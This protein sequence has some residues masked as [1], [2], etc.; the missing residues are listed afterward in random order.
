VFALFLTILGAP[1]IFYVDGAIGTGT[2][3]AVQQKDATICSRRIQLIQAVLDVSGHCCGELVV[4]SEDVPSNPLLFVP[5][6]LAALREAFIDNPQEGGPTVHIV[7]C[8]GE[9][10]PY[11]AHDGR[12]ASL[13]ISDDS[14]FMATPG[15]LVVP[16]YGI[17]STP[18]GFAFETRDLSLVAKEL[19]LNEFGKSHIAEFV[20]F[21]GNDYTRAL[22]E[23]PS[24]FQEGMT[25]QSW[26]LMKTEERERSGEP[27]GTK[28]DQLVPLVSDERALSGILELIKKNHVDL[29]EAILFTRRSVHEPGTIVKE[30][31]AEAG[32]QGEACLREMP[33]SFALLKKGAWKHGIVCED[34]SFSV[35]SSSH[36][37]MP[38]I[39]SLFAACATGPLFGQPGS[40][41]PP[42]PPPRVSFRLGIDYLED[43]P[44][45]VLKLV[46]PG[47]PLGPLT[48]D[49][50]FEKR[51]ARVTS[52][53]SHCLT[54]SLGLPP[55]PIDS[56]GDP[57]LLLSAD[58]SAF[59][60]LLLAYLVALSAASKDP[61]TVYEYLS[62]VSMLGVLSSLRDS[63]LSPSSFLRS[64]T[65]LCDSR[66]QEPRDLSRGLSDTDGGMRDLTLASRSLEILRSLGSLTL[67]CGVLRGSA[68]NPAHFFHG[69]LF[70]L[71]L[72]AFPKM[73]AAREVHVDDPKSAITPIA[74][75]LRSL[76]SSLVQDTAGSEAQTPSLDLDT[77]SAEIFRL[78][79][80]VNRLGLASRISP[81]EYQKVT[82]PP[83]PAPSAAIDQ[84][85]DDSMLE[86]AQSQQEEGFLEETPNLIRVLPDPDLPV[87]KHRAEIL[88]TVRNNP[89]VVIEADTGAGKSSQIP[90]Y[91]LEET[92]KTS[93]NPFIVCTQPRR[94]SAI[95][96]AQR[97]ARERGEESGGTVSYA[98][99]HD[100]RMSTGPKKTKILY[101]T[102]G[103]LLQKILA[104]EDFF[105]SCSH[106][107]LDEI[108]ERSID[109]DL[110]TLLL[111]DLLSQTLRGE[112]EG[113]AIPPKLLLMSATVNGRLYSDYFSD[114]G[115][116]LPLRPPIL[117]VGG[118]LFPVV[119]H[120]LDEMVSQ[121]TLPAVNGLFSEREWLQYCL[122]FS[123]KSSVLPD[124]HKLFDL[125]VGIV[126][127]RA[128][129]VF[130]KGV[131]S[132]VLIF[133]PGIKSIE[134][135][136]VDLQECCEKFR[137]QFLHRSSY[138]VK[139]EKEG[140]GDYEE[141]E[142]EEEEKEANPAFMED[143]LR[144]SAAE[145]AEPLAPNICG[146]LE[147]LVLH[148]D[149][150]PDEQ[151]LAFSPPK[152]PGVLRVVLA[153]NL[154][155]SS[156]TIPGVDTVIDFGLHRE[157]AFDQ[158]FN[159]NRLET[160]WIARSSAIQ[161]AGRAG[162]LCPGT[163]WRLFTRTKFDSMVQF[164]VPE[165]LRLSLTTTVLRL[166][167]LAEK[168]TELRQTL[169]GEEG[170]GGAA[171]HAFS[172]VG[173]TLE[174]ALQPP[175]PEN[176]IAAVAQ[177][178][179]YGSL[180]RDEEEG[181]DPD[182]TFAP[183][184]PL[185]GGAGGGGGR[186]GEGGRGGGGGTME[187]VDQ[188]LEN[189]HVTKL[190]AF[191]HLLPLD[192][193]L[194]RLIALG[195]RTG[196]FFP[197]AIIM[198]VGLSLPSFYVRPNPLTW[199]SDDLVETISA[200]QAGV[201][202]YDAGRLSDA[203]AMIPL[204]VD[205]VASSRD[206]QVRKRLISFGVNLKRLRS[207]LRDVHE[208]TRRLLPAMP[209]HRHLLQMFL[210]LHADYRA[211]RRE[212][213]L[214]PSSINFLR[215]LVIEAL[216]LNRPLYR[217][218]VVQALQKNFTSAAELGAA[219][220][221]VVILKCSRAVPPPSIV[222]AFHT[223]SKN[224]ALVKVLRSELSKKQKTTATMYFD[225]AT[226]RYQKKENTPE[227]NS[228]VQTKSNIFCVAFRLLDDE[229]YKAERQLAEKQDPSSLPFLSVIQRLPALR[230]FLTMFMRMKSFRILR[231]QASSR[232]V[233]KARSQVKEGGEK[234]ENQGRRGR[235]RGNNNGGQGK[236]DNN[237]GTTGKEKYR[238]EEEE[239]EEEE[240]LPEET[241]QDG[242]SITIEDV[243]SWITF[244]PHFDAKGAH[245][246]GFS[247]VSNLAGRDLDP[248]RRW[249]LMCVASQETFVQGKALSSFIDYLTA[250]PDGNGLLAL[251]LLLHNSPHLTIEPLDAP[252]PPK[253]QPKK[254]R[255]P[256]ATLEADKLR[257]M[258]LLESMGPM[259]LSELRKKL[260][261]FRFKRTHGVPIRTAFESDP[262]FVVK[263]KQISLAASQ[264]AA[265]EE[266]EGEEG[267]ETRKDKWISGVVSP[268]TNHIYLPL[269]PKVRADFLK[270]PLFEEF[271]EMISDV[272]GFESDPFALPH[273]KFHER[274]LNALL[275]SMPLCIC[276]GEEK[277]FVEGRKEPFEAKKERPTAFEE[278]FY[279]STQHQRQYQSY[280][281]V[282]QT[283]KTQ[284]QRTQNNF[285]QPKAQAQ[286]SNSTQTT[287]P[288]KAHTQKPQTTTQ[289]KAQ[290]QKSQ[291]SSAQT[292][293]PPKAQPKVTPTTK[294]QPLK[295]QTTTQQ[296][297]AQK[298]QSQLSLRLLPPPTNTQP[299][300]SQT[301]T[302]QPKAQAQQLPPSQP[303][304]TPTAKTQ[305]QKSQTTTQQPKVQT[306]TAKQQQSHNTA[307]QPK[308]EDF[309]EHVAYY[310]KLL[311]YYDELQIF[312]R[313]KEQK[314][315]NTQY[316][317]LMKL[318]EPQR[319][320][321]KKQQILHF[322]E[323]Q[324]HNTA[325]LNETFHELRT[326]YDSLSLKIQIPNIPTQ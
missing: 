304:A 23:A 326:L 217:G 10:D 197:H 299:L 52:P 321:L 187:D 260:G 163:V 295:S 314:L 176:V 282:R 169:A 307:A 308:G 8:L 320:S 301:T 26:L 31:I 132:T 50:S 221:H 302:Q 172:K 57:S 286:K 5:A 158:K 239:E 165:M 303:K 192:L 69:P 270:N 223:F 78:L 157:V 75:F 43:Q 88:E 122:A 55:F 142:E 143:L 11:L 147:V 214:P 38:L 104:S 272:T 207:F 21:A 315:K 108:H 215:L 233:A 114:L 115:L 67:L 256:S 153:T 278:E 84:L 150:E 209:K 36:V 2:G 245:L 130:T 257:G 42:L 220:E 126:A 238:E 283:P 127:C 76:L 63:P 59:S 148:S 240:E 53:L 319:G 123:S 310:K 62:F 213:V 128:N 206:F 12:L 171:E 9:A 312:Y 161:R 178:V 56:L 287:Q 194:G 224:F 103:W 162:R 325:K 45:E 281:P 138:R 60:S 324:R 100:N 64:V 16:N 313:S 110:L 29:W 40:L 22:L 185:G 77:C 47:H 203:L 204:Y 87:A 6:A 18:E 97:V 32:D 14:D 46:G 284:A 85:F 137:L 262:R 183:G 174:R 237:K 202:H 232:T 160:K 37:T 236:E 106:V 134:D 72:R 65:R 305:L 39:A 107:I 102:I 51:L 95:T 200:T 219:G 212:M 318:P 154:A 297:K 4:A 91:L 144:S 74:D 90:Q 167:I 276:R 48:Q 28:L 279:R 129:F 254:E 83:L 73:E 98:I 27:R 289:P 141:E 234:E 241:L 188:I 275:A 252:P 249:T 3:L 140:E 222:E 243:Q 111:R 93:Q 271:K 149:I 173:K 273:P 229:I 242:D 317:E 71:C 246:D 323:V 124:L 33:V 179:T 13:V 146:A 54:S 151:L 259:S 156:V 255:P 201:L 193:R 309:K 86:V 225:Y 298:S 288:T 80:F 211:F 96:L 20:S 227:T 99:G 291:P 44:V 226:G 35:P 152:V 293:Q 235:G 208:I 248:G 89:V 34:F 218:N 136:H 155:E 266:E 274:T 244:E 306:T 285:F 251:V 268:L 41:P 159:V 311:K 81:D 1:V 228:E 112:R 199:N 119:I 168:V 269:N 264:P 170:G 182:A 113:H 265:E 290:A 296:P 263:G 205:A 116:P 19:G 216:S 105:W 181:E 101:V 121:S 300:K 277:I 166:K 118:R 7:E 261:V 294:T 191:I 247:A 231:S 49:E 316:T 253:T 177:L 92:E 189:V 120:H 280:P 109:S 195:A 25:I 30:A 125:A 250:I 133:L 131:N 230:T 175:S 184:V 94:I 61:L 24:A 267:E 145:D 82:G 258:K 198:A 186:R 139:K 135:M 79:S 180:A 68:R 292:T 15:L 117:F 58:K 210:D 196:K 190:G 164:D 17:I 70:S 66:L 322:T